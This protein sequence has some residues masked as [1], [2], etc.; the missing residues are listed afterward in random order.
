[1]VICGIASIPTRQDALERVLDSI[2]PQVDKVYVSLNDYPQKPLYASKY[3]NVEFLMN[4]NERGDAN[5]FIMAHIP[6]VYYISLDDDLE[7]PPTLVQYLCAGVDKYN[8]VCGLHGRL[9]PTPFIGF[10]RWISNYR[11]LNT[12]EADTFVNFIGSG[13]TAFHTNRLKVSLSDFK[14]KNMADVFISQLATLQGVPMVVLK[15]DMGYLKY[16]PPSDTPIWNMTHDYSYHEEILR[17]FIK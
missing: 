2:A 3:D 10:K 9:Y 17:E 12:V 16:L 13:V 14:R 5:K 11:C 1:M 15:H 4:S 6:D 8:G 7:V